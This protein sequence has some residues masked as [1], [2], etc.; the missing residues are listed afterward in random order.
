MDFA[1]LSTFFLFLRPPPLE[2]KCQAPRPKP[3]FLK[4]TITLGASYAHWA[5]G[6]LQVAQNGVTQIAGIVQKN[7]EIEM[8]ILG[9]RNQI[10]YLLICLLT[11]APPLCRGLQALPCAGPLSKFREPPRAGPLSSLGP[12]HGMGN[13]LCRW[14]WAMDLADLSTF[15]CS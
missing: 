9:V 5:P 3:Y 1:D 6:K 4:K 7:R 15:F 14:P 13:G 2:R 8:S 12:T 10:C 11:W